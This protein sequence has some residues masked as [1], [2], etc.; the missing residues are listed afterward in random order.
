MSLTSRFRNFPFDV[1]NYF[2]VLAPP[3]HDIR[4]VSIKMCMHSY[5]EPVDIVCFV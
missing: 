2:S 5:Q 3:M 1:S 4:K